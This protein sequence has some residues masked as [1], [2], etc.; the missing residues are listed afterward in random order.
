[1]S[2]T[3]PPPS[4]LPISRKCRQSLREYLCA[5]LVLTQSSAKIEKLYGKYDRSSLEANFGKCVFRAYQRRGSPEKL[6]A[7]VRQTGEKEGFPHHRSGRGG[8]NRSRTVSMQKE[9]VYESSFFTSLKPASCGQCGTFQYAEFPLAF[10][11]Y[12]QTEPCP[13][14]GQSF[15]LILT[16]IITG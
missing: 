3:K 12:D 16:R 5:F 4:G 11:G 10:Q 15:R 1:M 14:S 9:E 6:S 13:P 7:G 2:L 8:S